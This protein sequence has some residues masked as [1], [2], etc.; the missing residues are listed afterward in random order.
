VCACGARAWRGHQPFSSIELE[1]VVLED[2]EGLL[3]VCGG[4]LR[5]DD[6][7]LVQEAHHLVEPLQVSLPAPPNNDDRPRVAHIAHIPVIQSQRN[8]IYIYILYIDNKNERE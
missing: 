8:H 2:P 4:V 1:E 3:E 7:E 6:V 5:V